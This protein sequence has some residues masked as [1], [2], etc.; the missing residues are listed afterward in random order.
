MPPEAV[1][2]HRTAGTF[3]AMPFRVALISTGGTIEKT[4]D[5]LHGVL[6]NGISVL[7]AILASLGIPHSFT[8]VPGVDHL[9]PAV[10]SG[11]GQANW[12]F[13]NASLAIPCRLAADIDCDGTVNGAD[14][15]LLLAQW[16]PGGGSADLD[17]NGAVDGADLGTLLAKWGP[18][19]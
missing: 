9:A 15:G 12:D 2:A 17:G 14:L 5:E 6:Q 1:G 10:L 16:G 11:L 18:V 7:D 8:L 4:F 3:R 13:Y 19:P